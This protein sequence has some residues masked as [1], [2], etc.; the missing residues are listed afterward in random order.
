MNDNH[1][2]A[3]HFQREEATKLYDHPLLDQYNLY[4]I[5]KGYFHQQCMMLQQVHFRY[6]LDQFLT[7]C[8]RPGRVMKD[9]VCAGV[10]GE[11]G[12]G[13]SK[14]SALQHFRWRLFLNLLLMYLADVIF[15]LTRC[16]RCAG[17]FLCI[18]EIQSMPYL[19]NKPL[20]RL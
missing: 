3:L 12:N 17:S 20:R 9:G 6:F 5:L 2:C 4:L 15:H 18:I 11:E 1:N 13:C 10:V 16:T 7:L 14:I 8:T 19:L